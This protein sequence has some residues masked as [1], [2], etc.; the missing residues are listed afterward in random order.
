MRLILLCANKFGSLLMCRCHDCRLQLRR[1]IRVYTDPVCRHAYICSNLKWRGRQ[2]ERNSDVINSL[3]SQLFDIAVIQISGNMSFIIQA[4]I[5]SVCARR[6][7]CVRPKMNT[8]SKRCFEF[9][10]IAINAEG[11]KLAHDIDID[12][13]AIDEMEF[14]PVVTLATGHAPVAPD[15]HTQA[16]NTHT[17]TAIF[18]WNGK[19]L[20]FSIGAFIPSTLRLVR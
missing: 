2:C 19:K 9:G 5:D 12:H 17:N 15:R 8:T 14:A 4:H 20:K 6:C 11:K 18:I 1:D 16:S 7:S 10:Q 3:G 13:S